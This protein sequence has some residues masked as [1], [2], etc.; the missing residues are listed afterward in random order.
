MYVCLCNGYREAELRQVAQE[1]ITSAAEAY[2]ALG[3]GPCCGR[4]LD[5]AQ[6]II[7]QVRGGAMAPAFGG[8]D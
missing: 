8:G 6:Q 3:N 4:C 7:D 5:C 1:G 2:N